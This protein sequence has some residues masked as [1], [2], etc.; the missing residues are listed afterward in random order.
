MRSVL[1]FIPAILL[2]LSVKAQSTGHGKIKITI[3]NE[4]AVA[5]ENATVELIK[6]RDS[7]LVKVAISD[8]SGA[9][10]FE[11]V[12][13]GS[14]LLKATMVNYGTQYSSVAEV[15]ASQAELSLPAISQ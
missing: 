9:A 14:Y 8:K 7:S 10:E 11:K 6:A 15:S 2:S 1:L 12:S 3:M 13:F 5:L 4:K